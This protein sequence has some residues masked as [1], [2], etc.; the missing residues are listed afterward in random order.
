MRT[1]N[2]ILMFFFT[3]IIII[4]C[5]S[6]NSPETELFINKKNIVSEFLRNIHSLESDTNINPIAAFKE[7]AKNLA[8]EVV[9]LS[10]ENIGSIL[11]KSKDYSNCI[12]VTANHTIVKIKSLDN[13]QQSGSWKVCMPYVEGYIKKGKLNYKKDYM[14]NVIGTPDNQERV[15]YFFS[16]AKTTNLLFESNL[17]DSS[18][19]TQEIC[20][21]ELNHDGRSP[22]NQMDLAIKKTIN[23]DSVL[24]VKSTCYCNYPCTMIYLSSHNKK[25]NLIDISSVFTDC[26]CPPEELCGWNDIEIISDTKYKITRVSEEIVSKYDSEGHELEFDGDIIRE[27]EY[28]T[29]EITTNGKMELINSSKKKTNMNIF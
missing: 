8:S 18:K 28:E 7:L 2:K 11:I 13:C 1:I 23:L 6:K 10:K 29:Y 22:C 26:D 24:V 3:S 5:N 9:I 17:L 15:A 19:I 16:S 14:N 21:S 12:I 20:F 4:G 27:Y 25:G